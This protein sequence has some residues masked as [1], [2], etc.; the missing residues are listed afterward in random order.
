MHDAAKRLNYS[1]DGAARGARR[2][3]S[4]IIAIVVADIR[5]FFFADIVRGAEG[6]LALRGYSVA[7][8]NSDE[9]A[10]QE[11]LHLDLA[12]RAPVSGVILCP[13]SPSTPDVVELRERGIPV[14]AVDRKVSVDIDVVL[15]DNRHGAFDAT[16]HLIGEEYRRIACITG[17]LSTTTGAE[18]LA[19]W[20]DA[21]ESH[22]LEIDEKLWHEGNFKDVDARIAAAEML[23]RDDRPDAF[24]VANNPMA[25]GVIEAIMDAEL[26]IPEDVGIV[27]YD[28][29][30]WAK[31]VRPSL[32]VV[33]QPSDEMGRTA[34]SL[35]LGRL[36]GD[37]SPPREAVLPTSLDIG[38][39]SRG[40]A[41]RQA[42][43][44]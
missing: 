14:V 16:S 3:R 36:G 44:A 1:L 6:A 20:R 5:N 18:R 23:R 29:V 4:A 43:S 10:W 39:S 21:H 2:Q 42:A 32:S 11:H 35:L 7:L 25:M 27:G 24:F 34:A 38:D 15:A 37:D 13:A 41:R 40:R 17:P 31:I 9:D 28:H 12:A 8:F 33:R 19:G 30:P 22:G 26:K